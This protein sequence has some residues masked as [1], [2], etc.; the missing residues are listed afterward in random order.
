MTVPGR[1]G[2]FVSGILFPVGSGETCGS[3]LT[4]RESCGRLPI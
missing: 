1:V 4:N 3:H 2:S